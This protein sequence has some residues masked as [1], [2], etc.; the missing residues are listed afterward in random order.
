MA[1]HLPAISNHR[2]FSPSLALFSSRNFF[3]RL[4]LRA[5]PAFSSAQPS[6]F[7]A[8]HF[9]L[10]EAE[11]TVPRLTGTAISEVN[12]ERDYCCRTPDDATGG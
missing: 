7:G 5:D 4:K 10:I 2:L 1:S 3:S 8:S 9:V 6:R 11:G 12:D